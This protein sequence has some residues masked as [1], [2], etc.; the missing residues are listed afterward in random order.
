LIDF[1]KIHLHGHNAKALEGNPLLAFCYNRI[2]VNTGEI[3]TVNKYGQKITPFKNATYLGLEFKIY[4]SGLITIEGSLHKYWNKGEHNFNDFGSVA[5]DEVIKDLWTKFNI[6]P[7][8]CVLKQLEIG[9][10]IIPPIPTNNIIEHCFL[11]KTTPFEVIKNSD[12]GKYIQAEH[13]QY[14]IKV[15]NKKL[16]YANKG[17]KIDNEI[18]RFEIKYR[19]M[20]KLNKI[21]IFTL[22]DLLDHGVQN[23]KN[24]LVLEWSNILFYDQTIRHNTKRLLK[25]CNPLYWHG[26][27]QNKTLANFKKHKSIL[28]Q[29]TLNDSLQIH[30]KVSGI[31]LKKVNDLFSTGYLN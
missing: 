7:Q 25:Y 13:S 2:D 17:F 15:Y 14:F 19:K 8:Q 12:E 27:V 30:E 31:M 29:L 4:D 26:L 5:L 18:L 11:H 28:K 21:G 20:E 23:F 16:H 1:I 24:Q 10:N 9:V 22:G 3:S 6:A